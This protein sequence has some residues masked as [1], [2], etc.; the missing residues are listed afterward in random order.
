MFNRI[1]AASFVLVMSLNSLYG[2]E[3]SLTD[4]E[5]SD[6]WKLLFDGKTTKGWVSIKSEPLPDSHVQEG[7]LN[8]H[9]CNYMLV[10]E[11]PLENYVLAMDFKITPKCNSGIFIR[12]STLT[13]RPGRDVGFN[14]IEI[15]VDDTRTAGFHD[16][17]AIYDLVQPKVN[18]M[19]PV[20]EWNHIQITSNGNLIEVELN[21]HVVSKMNLDE[22]PTA[23]KRPDGSA[24]KFDVAYK[25]H[26]RKGYIGLQ[27]HGSD[28]WYRNIKLKEIGK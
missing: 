17:A 28:C 4:R 8:P 21:G 3:N 6:G 19:K 9:P 12:T 2:E 10:Y 15:A 25:D 20:G 18:A 23:N 26:P 27:D 7:S 13:P 16:T 14:G 24:H 5:R 22:W 1:V 11:K